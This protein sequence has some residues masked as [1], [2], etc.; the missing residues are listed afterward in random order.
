M[1][2]EPKSR[3][4]REFQST[5]E[6]QTTPAMP[7]LSLRFNERTANPGVVF[8][9]PPSGLIRGN[10]PA[11]GLCPQ[12]RPKHF[13][14]VSESRNLWDLAVRAEGTEHNFRISIHNSWDEKS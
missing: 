6:T 14:A 10:S 9:R 4:S 3:K 11:A 13:G 7:D 1:N 5:N 8:W 2:R 12:G